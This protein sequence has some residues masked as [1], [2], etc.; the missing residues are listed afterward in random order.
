MVVKRFI[1]YCDFSKNAGL[2]HLMR[3]SA[4]AK[5]LITRGYSV[6]FISMDSNK[7][8]ISYLKKKKIQI[9]PKKKN[10]LIP[11]LNSI[12]FSK[13]DVLIIDNY[14]LNSKSICQL[15]KYGISLVVIDDIAKFKIDADIILNQ[16]LSVNRKNYSNSNFSKIFF[17]QKFSLIRD[18]I[19][20][21]KRIKTK[22][23]NIFLSFGGGFFDPFIFKFLK[24]FKKIDN[25]LT[26]KV[27]LLFV[28]KN[29]DKK[30]IEK[31]LKNLSNFKVKYLIDRYDL[32]R[33]LA[34][35]DFSI[36]SGGVTSHEMIY[37][38]IPQ[39]TFMTAKNQE[40]N[41]K[42][43]KRYGLGISMGNIKNFKEK[44]FLQQVL[45]LMFNQKLKNKLSTKCKKFIDGKGAERSAQKII[46]YYKKKY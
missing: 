31:Y 11:L 27:N 20:K 24:V 32:S 34:T 21:I 46:N 3:S 7:K 36:N 29:F 22:E 14:S 10:M 35:C 33:Y 23:I 2:G 19:K 15:K 43:I 37:L 25:S 26:A 4:L 16:N 41:L 39:I 38:G 12:H 18:E 5:E 44:F 17:G 1:F 8:I 30:S 28:I 13:Q 42:I 40:M 45:N 6:Y 9:I